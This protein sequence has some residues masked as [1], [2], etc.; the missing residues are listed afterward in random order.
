MSSDYFQT[1]D[2]VSKLRKSGRFG[3]LLYRLIQLTCGIITKHEPSKTEWGYGGGDRVDVWCRWCNYNWTISR[4]EAVFL[5]PAF[6]ERSGLIG[7]VSE[8]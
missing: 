6:G 7:T 5:F 4:H 3:P 8:S 2:K 1:W